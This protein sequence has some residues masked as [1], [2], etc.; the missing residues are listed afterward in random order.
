MKKNSNFR[1]V[2]NLSRTFIQRWKPLI[3]DHKFI[4]YKKGYRFPHPV[5][6]LKDAEKVAITHFEPKTIKDK[7]ALN[8]IKAIRYIFD[9]ISGYRPDN[10]NESLYIRR[11]IFLETIAGVPGFIAAMLRHLNSLR[12][13][14]QDGGWIHH[15]LEEAENERMHLLT[16]LSVRQPG[17]ILRFLIMLSQLFFISG[18]GLVYLISPTIAHRFVGYLEEEAIK[19][20]TQLIKDIDDG[21]LPN[22]ED[23]PAPQEA[24][25][26]WALDNNAKIRD[27]IISIRADEV[28]HREFNHHFA[29]IPKDMP[30]EGHTLEVIEEAGHEKKEQTLDAKKEIKI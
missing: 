21:K 28:A 2:K 27:V 18:Y 16:F 1:I 3:P 20:Y 5:W 19:T 29:D 13:L 11:C 23:L 30:I 9:K 4:I 14:R 6:N 10:M 22:W 25:K 17:V 7:I 8:T 12:S 24:I 26:Y 15:L